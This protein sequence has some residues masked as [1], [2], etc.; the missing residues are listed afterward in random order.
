MM[1]VAMVMAAG[2]MIAGLAAAQPAN[3]ADPEI[4]V[5]GT[6]ERP[7]EAPDGDPRPAAERRSDRLAYDRCVM[8]AQMRQSEDAYVNAVSLSPEEAC[9]RALGMQDRKAVPNKRRKD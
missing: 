1:R 9:S 8:R 5:P 3:E 4:V 2:L 6:K 7:V